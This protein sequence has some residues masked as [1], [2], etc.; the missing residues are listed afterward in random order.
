MAATH[1]VQHLAIA[2]IILFDIL[3]LHYLNA[4][5]KQQ[6][7]SSPSLPWPAKRNR[8]RFLILSLVGAACLLDAHYPIT[9]TMLAIKAYAFAFPLGLLDLRFSATDGVPMKVILGAS[10]WCFTVLLRQWYLDEPIIMVTALNVRT[11]CVE[12]VR[13]VSLLL[14]VGILSDLLFS[15]MHRLSHHP[16]VYK[17][18]HKEHH[19]YTNHLTS[20]VLYHGTLL[21]DF[22]MPF[23]TTFGGIAYA[24]VLNLIGFSGQGYSNVTIYLLIFNTLLSHAHDIRCGKSHVPLES[25]LLFCCFC[26]CPT[27]HFFHFF[28]PVSL[29]PPTTTSPSDGTITGLVKFCGLPLP[30]SFEPVDQFWVDTAVG[31]VLG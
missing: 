4:A 2:T 23:T 19:E 18:H 14:C 24:C 17:T 25:L 5:K 30:T 9:S 31:F 20:L 27:R 21:D 3:A 26:V 16:S 11:V 22:L 1:P 15:P 29:F 10:L 6:Q 12:S 28:F 7:H 8:Y 13:Y